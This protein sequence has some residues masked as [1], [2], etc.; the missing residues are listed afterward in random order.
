MR[1]TALLAALLAVLVL[2]P[3]L[4]AVPEEVPFPTGKTTI[5]RREGTVYTVEGRQ[6]I[7]KGVEISCQKDVHIRG[8]G[9]G[10]TIVVEGAFKVHG[11][12]A[13]E[14]IFESVTV[15]LAEQFYDCH[16][17]MVF[18][19]G[20]GGGLK[21]P[22]KTA[23]KGK[24]FAENTSFVVGNPVDIRFQSGSIDFS[25]VFADDL[26]TV[27]A[28]GKVRLNIRD[29]AYWGGVKL[30]GIHDLTLRTCVIGGSRST[31]ANCRTVL[32]DGDK[33]TADTLELSQAE[34][35]AFNRTKVI[36][37]DIYSKKVIARS[38]RKGDK[39]ADRLV[40][41]RCWFEGK[42]S[43]KVV[44][45]QILVDASDSEDNGCEVRLGK[46][47]ARPTELAGE[48]NR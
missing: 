23:V 43:P 15:E 41:D 13:R 8:K 44:H 30:T 48:Q 28:E 37:C 4:T 5:L 17:D 3:A 32:L 16:L 36:K 33:V 11:V 12:T 26:V 2:P 18:F 27:T 34:A 31:I 6:V 40:L 45:E 19:R 7:K 35:G 46:L 38:P 42:Q 1:V 14:V 25:N 24:L 47:L 39:V 10:A 21:T 22:P 20:K 9:P 29:G